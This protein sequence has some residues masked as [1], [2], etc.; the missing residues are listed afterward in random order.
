MDDRVVGLAFKWS[1]VALAFL[2]LLTAGVVWYAKKKPGSVRVGLLSEP[3]SLERMQAEV[4]MARF[5][6]ITSEAGIRFTHSN[7]AY[8]DKL[9]P[10][11]M[12]SGVAFFDF[13]NDGDQD[14][15]FVNGRE[16]PWRKATNTALT[17]A[18]YRNDG[19]GR[20][21]DVTRNSGLDVSIYGT[22]IAVGDYDNDGHVDVL[23][24]GVGDNRL[25]HNE[26]SG[27]FRDATEE[28]GITTRSNDWSTSAAWVDI[29]NDGDLD[30]FVCHYVD[31]S[32]E[33]D[34][35]ADYRLPGI[36]RAYG[37]PMNFPGT[38]PV[39]Y[40]NDGGGRFSDVSQK[41]GVQIKTPGGAP[42]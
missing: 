27:R 21:D 20:F 33:I 16:W 29:E 37:P 42:R 34:M 11:T 14:L 31:W 35:Q 22:G 32:R 4:P 6:A 15:L 17:A 5:R 18:L 2:A 38:L 7:G 41:A 30:L 19:A 10:E 36:G 9:L 23:L 8:G 12:G 26:G 28:A 13:D 24:T 40:R 25:L 3:V 1:L 39:L